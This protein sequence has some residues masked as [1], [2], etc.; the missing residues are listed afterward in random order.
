MKS[1]QKSF[2][3][4]N[5]DLNKGRLKTQLTSLHTCPEFEKDLKSLVTYLKGLGKV[6]R[7]SEVIK[8]VKLV[9]VMPE[10]NAL[11]E[12]SSALRR[13]KTWLHS[14]TDQAWLNWCMTL[15]VHKM[16]TDSLPIEHIANEFIC[17]NSSRMHIFGQ[18]K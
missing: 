14:R 4:Y 1:S 16:K 2:T 13:I 12:R 9:L 10:T 17:R 5:N 11:S 15:H 3:F 6:E 8:V 18:L 7:D